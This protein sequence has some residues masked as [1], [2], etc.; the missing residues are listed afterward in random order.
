MTTNLGSPS[1]RWLAFAKAP[2]VHL[3]ALIN[4]LGPATVLLLAWASGI[5]RHITRLATS[6]N[7]R[8]DLSGLGI[9]A[10]AIPL[11]ALRGIVSLLG[12]PILLY[13]TG[14]LLGGRASVWQI[15][16]AA[17]LSGLPAALLVVPWTL[18]LLLFGT[19][20]L[21]TFQGA[22]ALPLR[23]MYLLGL[24]L[25]GLGVALAQLILL[26]RA[27]MVIHGFSRTCAWANIG[28]AILSALLLIGLGFAILSPHARQVLRLASGGA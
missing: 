23:S 8:H 3:P 25:L 1:G 6:Q 9:L 16:K 5:T 18:A 12:G 4:G 19:T 26:S 7:F 24:A 28:L 10:D 20:S 2:G 15:T 13:G 22:G 14:R 17:A 21:G 11:G 27:L